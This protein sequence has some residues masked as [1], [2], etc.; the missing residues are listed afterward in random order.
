MTGL[1]TGEDMDIVSFG[2]ILS[3]HCTV[4]EHWLSVFKN[5]ITKYTFMQKLVIVQLNY[6]I[7]LPTP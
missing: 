3:R 6:R 7:T 4:D 2:T 1:K 5:Q